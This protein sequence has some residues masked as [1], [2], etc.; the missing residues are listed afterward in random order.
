MRPVLLV[1]FGLVFALAGLSAP[2]AQGQSNP[3]PDRRFVLSHD[4]DLPGGDLRQIF[5]TTLEACGTACLADPRCA[6]FTYNSRANACFPKARAG[7]P[8]A[9]DGALSGRVVAKSEAEMALGAE[10]AAELRGFLAPEDLDQARRFA[11]DLANESLPGYRDLSALL[12]PDGGRTLRGSGG[13]RRAATATMRTDAP[14]HWLLMSR[15]AQGTMSS[16]HS[17]WSRRDSATLGAINAYLRTDDTALRVDALR[18][19]A[20]ALEDQRRGRD[21]IGALRMALDIA[22]DD[23]T[24]R[25]LDAAIAKYGFRVVDTQVESELAEP[26]ICAIFSEALVPAGRDYA[27]FV[28]LPEPG[29]TVE[30]DDRTLCIG[31]VR[32][33]T[34]YSIGLREG[35]PAASGEALHKTVDLALW[36]GDREPAVR[37]PGR[38][39]LLPATGEVTLPVVTL[40]TDEVALSLHR[41]SDRTILQAIQDDLFARP[42]DTWRANQLTEGLAET[43]WQGSGTVEMTLN[44]EVTTRLP[45]SDELGT[46]APGIYVLLARLPDAEPRDDMAAA[47]WFVVSD[48]GLATL[49]G[50]DGLHVFL[51]GL[52]DARARAGVRVRLLARSNAV[53]AAATTDADG[54]ARFA[55][56]LLNGTGGAAPALVLAQDGGD[57]TFL[58]LTEPEFDLSDRGVAGR[59]PA[60]PVDA[61][62][63]T[64]RGAYRPGETI[65]ATVLTRDD[66]AAA[67]PGLPVTAILTRPDGVEYRRL[68]SDGGVAGGHV[69]AFAT[70]ATVPRGRWRLAIHTDPEAPAIASTALLVEEFLPERIDA[71]LTLPDGPIGLRDTPELSV[72]ARYLFGAPA[73]DLPVEGEVALRGVDTLDGFPGYR[74][75]PHDADRTPRYAALPPDLRTGPDGRLTT[76]IELPEIDV[77]Y[78]P[79]QATAIVRVAEGSGRPIER[80]LTRPVTGEAALIGIKPGFDGVA[81]MEAEARFEVIA[82]DARGT[83]IAANLDWTLT[84][85]ERQYQWYRLGG[86]WR[87]EPITRRT[88]I[89]EGTL[90]SGDAPA[91]IAAA[92]DWGR[93]EL[94]VARTDGAF[95]IASIVFDAGGYGGADAAATPDFLEVSLDA[96]S[97]R[98]GDTARL[99][100]VP[101]APGRALVTVLS[102]RLIDMKAVE[103]VAGENLVD[104]PV[105]DDW[106]AGAYVTATVI[107][108]MDVPAGQNPARALGLAHA[109]VDPGRRALS[110]RFDMPA[111]AEPRGA[112]PVTLQIDG[113]AAGETAHATIAAV[114][115]GILNLTG[116]AAPDPSGHYFGQRRL[117]MAMRD[118][119]GRLIDGLNGQR[120]ALRSGGDRTAPGGFAAP[121]PTEAPVA[122]F[123]GP[124]QA[125][126]DGTVTAR[127]DLPSFNGTV[128]LMAVVWSDSGVGQASAE[129]LVRD[130]VVVAATLPRFLAPGDRSRLLLELTHTSGPAG[131]MA[132]EVA[133]DGV[134]LD[135]PALPATVRLD[136]AGTARIAVPLTADAAGLHRIAVALITPDGRRLTKSLT[137]SVV[138]NDPAIAQPDRFT[139]DPQ[140]TFTFDANVFAGFRPGTGA[141]TIAAGPIARLNVPGLL[142]ALDRYPYGCTEQ[143]TSR[144]LPLLY[145]DEVARAMGLGTRD[146]LGQRIDESIERVLANQSRN[147]AFGLWRPGSGDLW[148]DAYVTDF[149]SRARAQGHAVPDVAFQGALDNLRNRVNA[150][151][152]FDRG[153]TG[154]AYALYVLAREGM[155]SI[156]DL[157]YYADV[158]GEA[159][160]T[161]LASAQIGAALA[162]YGDP[163]RADRLFAQAQQQILRRPTAERRAWRADYG[164]YHRDSAAV[165]TLA[166]EAGSQAVDR[167]LVLARI[168]TSSR[169]LSTQEQVWT[170]LAAHALLRDTA[171]TRLLVDGAPP[172]GPIVYAADAGTAFAPIEIRNIGTAPAT[173]TLTRFGVPEPPEPAGGEGYFIERAYFTMDG[174]PADLSQPVA[175]GTRLIAVLTVTP[176]V[177]AEARLM[178]NDP[179]PAGFEI[180]NPNLLSGGDIRALD[181]LDVETEVQ[182]SQFPADRFLAA[183]DWRTNRPFRLA[184]I[185]RA[186]APGSYH[187]PAPLVEDMYRPAYRAIGETGRITVTE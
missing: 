64:D 43:V 158:K 143:V 138:A 74:F 142:A 30:V 12:G 47:Q 39:Y 44:A 169:H 163:E 183:I 113:I 125:G 105:T 63:T 41:M 37:F 62:L 77:A 22:P 176:S 172:D 115:L 116:F 42:L 33:A 184:Y 128:K 98:P 19:L 140:S 79:L 38:A 45:L 129:L 88:R 87:W 117:G 48:L 118:L 84:R 180:D 57:L 175:T 95:A 168:R 157:R 40:N 18:L 130:P 68:V 147:G 103:V 166:A 152:D 181:W 126:P 24:A 155:A 179:L 32:H 165:L 119:Y 89:A 69:F 127:F 171:A 186:V 25:A 167:D 85:L 56:G 178:V 114:D 1:A 106:G 46:L 96:A 100:I 177:A 139:L 136:A 73:G 72:A 4:V 185:V 162:A 55:P 170:L 75:G 11:L 174:A 102:N 120:G 29:L 151:P 54:Y 3:V 131:D 60:G 67:I 52:G 150:A 112:L 26:R 15:V 78:G 99:R 148:L 28:R 7:A 107:R 83:P 82:L 34:R 124:L 10:R 90:Q 86:E 160:A 51:R 123:A 110:A 156:G 49:S 146:Q 132:L 13:F 61:F 50:T 59:A 71:E 145:L 70:S 164:S 66:R 8:E 93:Y 91:A 35:L 53:L 101:R 23:D 94:E 6:A 149:L 133:A 109:A 104:L 108:P 122:F 154:I 58:S 121:P 182:A 187:H 2:Q 31:G 141:A 9:F 134:T 153:G 92:V 5:E 36:V 137:L 135:R 81:P 20:S 144:A 17:D 173:V 80:R 161:P 16:W 65:H 14:E 27:P 159:F 111:T 76:P 97:Y 21:M